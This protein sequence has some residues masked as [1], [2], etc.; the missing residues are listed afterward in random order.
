MAPWN[1][2]TNRTVGGRLSAARRVLH[3]G[4]V[5]QPGFRLRRIRFGIHV[6][7]QG[8]GANQGAP[9]NASDLFI[10]C[11]FGID[12]TTE[13][14]VDPI[15]GANSIDWLFVEV[16]PQQIRAR[17]NAGTINAYDQYYATEFNRDYLLDRTMTSP[18][19]MWLISAPL[20]ANPSSSPEWI[21]DSWLDVQ[22]L[23][24]P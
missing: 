16:M 15:G 11:R 10:G 3:D 23:S 4:A 24:A 1:P 17:S 6:W 12:T 5:F 14:G 21:I 18:L 7:T 22:Y 19:K 9:P 8:F 2:Q 20:P 13:P